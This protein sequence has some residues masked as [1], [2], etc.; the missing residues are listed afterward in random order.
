MIAAIAIMCGYDVKNDKVKTLAYFCLVAT[1]SVE[2]IK[3]L[4]I[5]IGEKVAVSVLKKIPGTLCGKINQIIGFRL[6]TKF[7]K[8]GVLNI[9]K[10]VPVVGGIIG[11]TFDILSTNTV[12]NIARDLFISNICLLYTSDAADE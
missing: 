7:G 10:G 6:L 3:D 5:K 11:A 4:G 8:K 12:G 9:V 2:I 1:S